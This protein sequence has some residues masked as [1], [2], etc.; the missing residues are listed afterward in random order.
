[1]A[2]QVEGWSRR[3]AAARTEP[4]P[5]MDRLAAWLEAQRPPESSPSPA[6]LVHNDFKLDNLVL[7]PADP[8]QVR[9]V[10]DWEMATVGDPL[11]DLGTTLAYWVE[12][13]DPPLFGELGLGITAR[14]G[15][16]TRDA[17]VEGYARVTGHDVSAIA[18][19]RAF[20]RFKLAV[21]AQQLVA[22]FARGLSGDA[23]YAR[24]GEVV[25]VLAAQGIA[26]GA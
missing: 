25:R 19:Y 1:V 20:G 5:D 22:R 11:M 14:P 15:A 16:W 10:L 9:A 3:W 8:P 4:V 2:R 24:L 18:F 6:V 7:D 26:H 21:V 17:L 12:P 23:R 13:G